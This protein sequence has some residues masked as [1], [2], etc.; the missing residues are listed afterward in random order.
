[1]TGTKLRSIV[2]KDM[3]YERGDMRLERIANVAWERDAYLLP[4]SIRK[5]M[6]I[7]LNE[8]WFVKMI[9]LVGVCNAGCPVQLAPAALEFQDKMTALRERGRGTESARRSGGSRRCQ[10]GKKRGERIPFSYPLGDYFSLLFD[11]DASEG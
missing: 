4:L 8:I 3:Q 1:M 2:T 7:Y 5:K 11:H 6:Y 10:F 9:L